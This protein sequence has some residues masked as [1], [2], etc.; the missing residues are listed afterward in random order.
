[1]VEFEKGYWN[2]QELEIQ[3]WIEPKQ[4]GFQTCDVE[5]LLKKIKSDIRELGSGYKTNE[6]IE[7]INKRFGFK[8]S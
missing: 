6:V 1:M 3:E 5:G 8:E 4:K 2:L 7:I